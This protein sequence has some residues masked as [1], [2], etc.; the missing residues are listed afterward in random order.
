MLRSGSTHMP[1][2][3]SHRPS[4]TRFLISSNS[5]GYFSSS[6]ALAFAVDCVKVYSGYSFINWV[7]GR[8]VS[9]P[10]FPVSDHGHSQAMSMCELPV[11][12]MD[13]LLN[14]SSSGPSAD[15]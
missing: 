7:E 1:P 14:G 12:R 10:T 15:C 8:K 11:T 6:H 9:R 3:N 5:S 13:F 2:T 4:C